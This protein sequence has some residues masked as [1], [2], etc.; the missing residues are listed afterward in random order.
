MSF[1]SVIRSLLGPFEKPVANAYRSIFIDLEMVANLMSRTAP[2]RILEIGCGEGQLISLLA[3]RLPEANIVGI[4]INDRVGRMYT[5]PRTRVTFANTD[6]TTFLESKPGPFDLVILCDVMHHIPSQEHRKVLETARLLVSSGG[7]LLL[8]DWRPTTSIIHFLAYFSDRFITGD[9]IQ[10][11]DHHYYH[12]LLGDLGP[13]DTVSDP[14]V[15]RPWSNNFL[16]QIT[17]AH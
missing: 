4:D 8:K 13:G 16:L 2:G 9:L 11:F 15:V 3:A 1:G 12:E 14:I 6:A 10:Y 7:V 5:G 17:V